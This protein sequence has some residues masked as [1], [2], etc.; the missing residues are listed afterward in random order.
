MYLR[1]VEPGPRAFLVDRVFEPPPG[2]EP[3]DVFVE[4]AFAPRESAVIAHADTALGHPVRP[5]S[6]PAGSA[7]FERL[8]PDAMRVDTSAPGPRFL[9]VGEHF[10]PGWSAKLDGLPT[11]VVA[12]DGLALGVWVPAGEHHLLLH[13]H[14]KGLLPSA[15]LA[16]VVAGLLLGISWRRRS[17]ASVH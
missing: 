4:D 3:V 7:T 15:G 11:A 14:P 13:F 1:E 2:Q 9:V 16:A 8:G 12:A 5:D 10:D 6:K 17:R